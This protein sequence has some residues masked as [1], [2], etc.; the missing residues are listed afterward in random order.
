MVVV[1]VGIIIVF[2]FAMVPHWN[3]ANINAFP[4]ASVF[5]RDV[6]LTI[7][8]CFFSAVFI[9]VLNPMNIATANGWRTGYWPHVW[10]YARIGSVTLR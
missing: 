4:E 5:F 9:Q 7:P 3:F 2:G 10:L 1:K 6:L 8:F